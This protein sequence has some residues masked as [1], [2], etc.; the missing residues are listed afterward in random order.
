MAQNLVER[1]LKNIHEKLS[2]FGAKIAPR[3]RFEQIEFA[4]SAKN[5][6][7]GSAAPLMERK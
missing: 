4:T 2:L 6:S 1:K 7:F 5:F 3:K